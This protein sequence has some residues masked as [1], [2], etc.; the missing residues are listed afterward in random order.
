MSAKE[1][2]DQLNK[3]IAAHRFHFEKIISEQWYQRLMKI[4][5]KMGKPS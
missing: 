4:I 3:E 5:E 2:V 1:R